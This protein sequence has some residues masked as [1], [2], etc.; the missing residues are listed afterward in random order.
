MDVVFDRDDIVVWKIDLSRPTI[1]PLF[2]Q[3]NAEEGRLVQ[4]LFVS[5]HFCEAIA[6]SNH[7]GDRD[8]LR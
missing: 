5:S 4:G 8:D 2:L 6:L 7:E 1:E 3:S